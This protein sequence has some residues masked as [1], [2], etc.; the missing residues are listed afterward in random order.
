MITSEAL[1]WMQWSISLEV[2]AR[3]YEWWTAGS[4]EICLKNYKSQLR[5]CLPVKYMRQATSSKRQ[6]SLDPSFRRNTQ[7]RLRIH[8]Y[9]RK[10]KTM[11]RIRNNDLTHYF[12]RDHSELPESYLKHCREF[13]ESLGIKTKANELQADKLQAASSKR[14]ADAETNKK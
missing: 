12:F 13:F 9:N 14:Q 8:D 6:A 3:R 1:P 10:D 11:K 7:T 4:N 2:N 5:D